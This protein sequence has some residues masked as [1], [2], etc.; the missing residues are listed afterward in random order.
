MWP[1]HIERYE[2]SPAFQHTYINQTA[3]LSQCEHVQDI[4]P[5]E[6]VQ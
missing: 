5:L 6:F 3:T 1:A 2:N 4:H